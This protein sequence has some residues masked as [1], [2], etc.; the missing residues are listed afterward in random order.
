[1]TS[2]LSGI[3]N[4]DIRWN[5]KSNLGISDT[6]SD[7][8]LTLTSNALETTINTVDTPVKANGFWV[9]IKSVHFVSDSTGRSTFTKETEER[10]PIDVSFGIK[11]VSGTNVLLTVYIAIN[12]VV[13]TPGVQVNSGS[14]RPDAGIAIWQYNFK[15]D[16][17]VEV[18]V[19]NNSNTT[20][21]VLVNSIMR[22]N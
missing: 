15:K 7:A 8:L 20:N 12:G 9:N 11:P 1:L 18:F 2:P 13:V 14:T 6:M 3:S 5:F 17:Y 4:E 21:V 19:E 10:L 22:N 16:D